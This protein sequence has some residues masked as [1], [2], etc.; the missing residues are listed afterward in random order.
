MQDMEEKACAK[1]S[2]FN[3]TK[4]FLSENSGPEAVEK[5]TN[6]MSIE[7]KNIISQQIFSMSWY[8]EE[9]YV[10]FLIAIDKVFG[11]GNYK[12]CHDVGYYTAIKATA[13]FYKI[14]SH[15]EDP[16]FVTRNGGVFWSKIHN[17]GR[18]EPTITDQNSATIRIIDKASPHKAFCHSV[19]GYW[20]GLLESGGAKDVSIRESKCVCR[21]AGFCE[22][23]GIWK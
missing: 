10:N 22:F 21:K 20:K 23:V 11:K 6:Q 5:V 4:E 3:L 8:P 2:L 14:F 18:L 16:S 12:L 9:T 13:R 7:D 1:G 15:S 19:I 17:N